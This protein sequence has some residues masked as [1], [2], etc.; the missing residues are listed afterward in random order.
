MTAGLS[1]AHLTALDLPPPAL[2]REAARAGFASVGLRVHPA[3]VD[4]PAYPTRVGT[5]AHRALKQILT[6]EGVRHAVQGRDLA[7]HDAVSR[8]GNWESG[9]LRMMDPAG[10]LIGIA[11][12]ADA[13]GLLHPLVVLI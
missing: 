11:E 12:P 9:Y 7:P 10:E 8:V 5:E 3:T 1:L 13:P 6:G 2:V 4:G